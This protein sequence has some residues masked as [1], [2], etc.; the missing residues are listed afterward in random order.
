MNSSGVFSP[1]PNQSWFWNWI[2]QAASTLSVV[3]GLKVSR[4]SS[5]GADLARARAPSARGIGSG[6]VASAGALRPKRL[7]TMPISGSVGSWR[8]PS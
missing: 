4:F 7:P 3:A 1:W 5:A 8:E 6:A 2:Q